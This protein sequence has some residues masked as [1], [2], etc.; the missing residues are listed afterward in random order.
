MISWLTNVI[1]LLEV[2]ITNN[3]NGDIMSQLTATQC[4]HKAGKNKNITVDLSKTNMR[5]H[6]RTKMRLR[7][8]SLDSM[9]ECCHCCTRLNQKYGGSCVL[10]WNKAVLASVTSSCRF[11]IIDEDLEWKGRVNCQGLG[12]NQSLLSQF[13]LNIIQNGNNKRVV[14]FKGKKTW[15]HN[16]MN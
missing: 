8:Q 7:S 11:Y 5:V 14:C 4:P 9:C 16:W 12:W 15:K 3:L 10:Q 1:M 6:Q 13:I 2:K